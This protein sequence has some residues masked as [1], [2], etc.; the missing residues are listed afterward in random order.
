[1]EAGFLP[2]L[3]KDKAYMFTLQ[4]LRLL[5][6]P[7]ISW[8]TIARLEYLRTCQDNNWRLSYPGISLQRYSCLFW[9]GVATQRKRVFS[10]V[11]LN[12][13]VV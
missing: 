1:M 3:D 4:E 13:K 5:A 2:A 9:C 8:D 7:W 11:L 10:T 6:Y 12:R